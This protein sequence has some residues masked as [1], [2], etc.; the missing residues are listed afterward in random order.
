MRKLS[1]EAIDLDGA[2][3]LLFNIQESKLMIPV[4][5]FLFD[6][7]LST[8][9]DAEIDFLDTSLII[10]PSE[11]KLYADK[12]IHVCQADLDY[13]FHVEFQLADDTAMATR[14]F[15]YGY[16]FARKLIESYHTV[17]F[18]FPHQAV[19]YFENEPSVTDAHFF[20]YPSMDSKYH[21]YSYKIERLWAWD[22]EQLFK[23]KLFM[24]YP[25]IVFSYRKKIDEERGKNG[26]SE[27]LD[28]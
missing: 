17:Y 15:E 10:R 23:E 12:Y 21:N 25:L 2:M 19:I 5:N 9:I 18:L 8:E 27:M 4:L 28:K 26:D 24:L 14:M 16:Y 20:S 7:K 6:T 1:K 22:K 11:P 13:Y 3:K